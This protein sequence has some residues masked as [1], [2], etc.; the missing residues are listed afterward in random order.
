MTAHKHDLNWTFDAPVEKVFDALTNPQAL[1]KWFAEHVKVEAKKGG[2]YQFW[3]K[4]SFG[5]ETSDKA[6]QKITAYDPQKEISFT[7]PFLGV[8]SEV[9]LSFSADDSDDN[10][11]GTKVTGRHTFS[12]LPDIV[13][14]KELID[15]LWRL[16]HGN[17]TAYLNGGEGILLPDYN[18]QSPEIRQTI[19]VDA[20][21]SE[22][23]KALVTPE[24]LAKWM[25]AEAAVVEPHKDG[26]YSYGW[27]YEVNGEKVTG[28]P[29]KILDIVENEKLVTDWPDWRGDSSVPV[30]TVSW[31]LE[32][33]GPGKTRVTLIHSGFTRAA[34]F[35]DFPFGW[36][37]FLAQL[38]DVVE[39]D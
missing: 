10:K 22:V 29:T 30:Q 19:V 3:G 33:A 12:A 14:A 39:N 27:N 9:S 26:K 5:V 32:D 37:D 4:H 38:K 16:Q 7:W 15:D 34:D 28:G 25:W 13:R 23:F 2:A 31:L 1:Q 36:A 17:L 11:G 18:D 35:S 21:R 8:D 24:I 20:P 6:T